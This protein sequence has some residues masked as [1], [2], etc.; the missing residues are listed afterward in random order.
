MK[1]WK[2][3]LSRLLPRQG[4][5][6]HAAANA[7]EALDLVKSHAFDLILLDICSNPVIPSCC[8]HVL[9]RVSKKKRLS[10]TVI[11]YRMR[12]HGRNLKKPP[13]PP[14]TRGGN[15]RF[16]SILPVTIQ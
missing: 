7:A 1:S 14:F 3:I 10:D 4:H 9:P 11:R 2:N 6:V 8:G 5:S 16:L 12:L 15:E 13:C